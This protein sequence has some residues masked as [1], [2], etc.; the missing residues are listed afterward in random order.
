MQVSFDPIGAKWDTS[1]S[2]YIS[3]VMAMGQRFNLIQF[4]FHSPSEHVIDGQ[5][6]E[7][8]LHFVHQNPVTGQLL[9]IGLLFGN[10]GDGTSPFLDQLASPSSIAS[11][12]FSLPLGR[13]PEVQAISGAGFYHYHGSLT[14]GTCG[15]PVIWVVSHYIAPANEKEVCGLMDSGIFETSRA[16][17]PLNGRVVKTSTFATPG[18]V[19]NHLIVVVV[20]S[21][22]VG[23]VL[24][25]AL[26]YLFSKFYR[27]DA[28]PRSKISVATK[29]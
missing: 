5:V 6:Y 21:G 13:H 22:V 20:I 3:H 28:G 12:R 4:H 14:A 9:V 2:G 27:S 29:A 24:L 8:E 26:G 19:Q 11:G 18:L 15:G 25:C 1:T 16:F 10:G 7:A 23:C 17:Q